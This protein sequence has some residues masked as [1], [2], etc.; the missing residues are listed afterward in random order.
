[1][2]GNKALPERFTGPAYTGYPTGEE[3]G[4]R[5]PSERKTTVRLL[6]RQLYE[7]EEHQERMQWQLAGVPVSASDAL[8]DLI[9]AGSQWLYEQEQSAKKG[10]A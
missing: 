4:H 8:R 1:M 10:E 7:I 2:G 3:D 6:R 9:S 5:F